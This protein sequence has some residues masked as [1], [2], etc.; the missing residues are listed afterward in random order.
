M[1][2]NMSAVKKEKNRGEGACQLDQGEAAVGCKM[3]ALGL[4]MLH[5]AKL[6]EKSKG[7]QGK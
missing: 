7:A 6:R 4:E 3:V 5:L 2:Q 1:R